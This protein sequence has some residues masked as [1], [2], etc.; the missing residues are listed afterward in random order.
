MS[1]RKQDS[2]GV[3]MP[4]WTGDVQR[5]T[6]ALNTYIEAYGKTVG[7]TP[8][9]IEAVKQAGDR[10]LTEGVDLFGALMTGAPE[11]LPD[12]H[13]LFQW[14]ENTVSD[15]FNEPDSDYIQ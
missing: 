14:L 8:E 4:V 5:D 7:A 12:D 6:E 11:S 13:E 3:E 15:Q 1:T 9:R 10:I 2:K